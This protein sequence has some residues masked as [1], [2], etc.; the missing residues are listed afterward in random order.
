MRDHRIHRT[1]RRRASA[2]RR[3]A[4]A[5]VPRLRFGRRRH[6]SRRID[7]FAAQ[8]RQAVEP[9]AGDRIGPDRR[10]LRR[11]PHALGDARTANRGKRASPPRL[12]WQDCRCAQRHH[13]ELPRPEAG[14]P[15]R[16]PQARHGNRHRDRRASGRARNEGRLAWRTLS[17]ARSSRSAASS[18]WSSCRPTI[19]KR[20]S[21]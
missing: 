15:A 10:R 8:R 4:K 6:R 19:P 17:A 5:R 2:D 1:Q 16:G 3:A 7:Q 21:R 11:R 12:H 20:S 14:A 18:P 13:R 9:R